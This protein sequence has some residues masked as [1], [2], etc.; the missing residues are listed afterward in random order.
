MSENAGAPGR[1][2]TIAKKDFRDASQSRAL[3]TITTVLVLMTVISSYVY[4]EAPE[5]F[6]GQTDPTFEG[7]IFFTAAGIGLFIPLIAII[8]CYKSVAGERELGSIKIMM[9]LPATRTDVFFGKVLGRG[10]VISSA[11]GVGVVIGIALGSLLMGTFDILPALVFVL[12]TLVFALVYTG[13][14]VSLSAATGSTTRATTYAVGFFVFFELLWDVI[15]LGILYIVEG[16][17]LPAEIPDWFMTFVMV[18]PTNAFISAINAGLPVVITS[19][20]TAITGVETGFQ[21]GDA[22]YASSEMGFVYLAL[23]LVVPLAIGY[24]R[25]NRADL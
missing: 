17:S 15:P 3:W 11:L 14:M 5:L 21:Y 9:S 22:F 13:I 20:D 10:A 8:A 19:D 24:Y 12:L 2:L 16:F 18:A 4:V 7:L 23:W 1:I 6:G 25:F